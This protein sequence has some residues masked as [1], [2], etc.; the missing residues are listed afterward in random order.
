MARRIPLPGPVR[1]IGEFPDLTAMAAISEAVDAVY[2]FGA[3]VLAV[4]PKRG[5]LGVLYVDTDRPKWSEAMYYARALTRSYHI[6]QKE[7]SEKKPD[8]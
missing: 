8:P 1:L 5:G 3:T 4:D 6:R 2:G 7:Q